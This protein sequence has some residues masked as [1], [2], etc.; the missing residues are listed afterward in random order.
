[1]G[2][3]SHESYKIRFIVSGIQHFVKR[4]SKDFIISAFSPSI[5]S[6]ANVDAKYILQL[7]YPQAIA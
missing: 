7:A 2:F 4:L 1:M 6:V 5:R 3:F